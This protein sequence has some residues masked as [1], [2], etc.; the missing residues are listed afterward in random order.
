MISFIK[1][2][3]KDA[4]FDG[5]VLQS[6][7]PVLAF[8]SATWNGPCKALLPIVDNIGQEY[9]GKVKAVQIDIDDC[10]ETAKKYGVKS[11]PTIL[12]FNQGQKVGST[13]GLTSRENI[14]KQIPGL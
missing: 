10:N 9:Q 6:P 12:I 14:I 1:N 2:I 13:V 3:E 7:V 8:F 4:E 5:E 11:V